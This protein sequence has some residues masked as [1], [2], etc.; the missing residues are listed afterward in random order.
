MNPTTNGILPRMELKR[1]KFSSVMNLFFGNDYLSMFM[2]CWSLL[3]ALLAPPKLPFLQPTVDTQIGK[4]V[5]AG[6][7]EWRMVYN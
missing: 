3:A 7:K 4:K 5:A 1:D 2:S 6:H